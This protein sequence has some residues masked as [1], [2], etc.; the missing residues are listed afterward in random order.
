MF[1]PAQMEFLSDGRRL[2]LNH[3]PIDLIIQAVGGPDDVQ[4]SYNRAK[5]FF[6]EILPTLVSELSHLRK[7]FDET[8]QPEGSVARRMQRACSKYCSEFLTPMAAVAGAVADEVLQKMIFGGCLQKA[9]INNGGDIAFHLTRGQSLTAGLVT[10][11]HIPHLDGECLLTFEMPVRGIATSGWKGRSFSL[12]I[13][14][15]V[16]VLAGDGASADV[17]ATLIANAVNTDHPAVERKP[18]STQD[19]DSDLNDCLVTTRV[20]KLDQEAVD[21]ALNA[22]EKLALKIKLSGHIVAAVL[23]LQNNFRV[24]GAVPSGFVEQKM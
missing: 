21:D 14:D 7:P 20:G 1:A 18:A 19:P 11:Y 2:H 17:A 22:G 5:E 24:V 8:W 10:D 13:A 23:V 15:S 16:T 12:G 6:P 4:L 9:Y 3:G